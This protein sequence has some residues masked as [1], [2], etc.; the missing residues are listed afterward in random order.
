MENNV[1]KYL[2]AP[3]WT[4]CSSDEAMDRERFN[5]LSVLEC[6]NDTIKANPKHRIGHPNRCVKK[7]RR[8]AAA[9]G[10]HNKRKQS[11][12]LDDL[13]T[14]VNYLLGVIFCTQ[15]SSPS[16]TFQVSLLQSVLFVDDRIRAVQVDLTTMMGQS[17]SMIRSSDDIRQVRNIQAKILRYHLLSQHLLSDFTSKEYEWKFGHKAL[18]T[19]ITSYFATWD[20][21]CHNNEKEFE[22]LDEIMSYST[23]L[24][25]ASI[26]ASSE[27]S[28][29]TYLGATSSMYKW[30]GLACEDGHGVSAIL[31]IYRKYCQNKDHSFFPKY[32]W[33][34][35]IAT[36]IENGNYLSAIRHLSVNSNE[37]KV[38]SRCCVS[39]VMPLIRIGLLRL[40]NKSFMKREKI[41][42]EDV[43]N[44]FH[45]FA[46]AITICCK[47]LSIH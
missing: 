47:F 44:F 39:E 11:R 24:H 38:L 35:R 4:M 46:A 37:G 43:S 1:A 15:T 12:S 29:Q 13:E 10:V 19:A 7:Y 2:P 5:E 20:L 26:V 27:P 28:V 45:V 30:R 23:L 3:K 32:H 14:T 40:Y 16:G 34:L 9:G 41:F 25:I 31:G 42:D 8:S 6:T 36:S 22:I 17:S 21:P 18:T 33:A